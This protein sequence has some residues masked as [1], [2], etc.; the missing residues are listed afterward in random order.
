MSIPIIITAFGTTS[1][2]VATYTH[3]DAVIR[4]HFPNRE[5]IWTYS[6]RVVGRELQKAGS[7]GTLHPEQ[8]LN[9]LKDKGV[10]QAIVQS[11]HLF[12]GTEF[13]TLHRTVHDSEIHSAIGRPL[14]TSFHDYMDICD[15]LRPV[16]L[17]QQDTAILILG[18]G[19]HHPIWTA[20]Y[21]LEK[22][23]RQKYGR[24]IFVGTV[25]PYPDSSHLVDDI[26]SQGFKQV[27][28]IP[29]FL[30]AG[31]HFRRDIIG[32]SETSWKSR[33]E[34]KSIDVQSI[35]HGIGLLPG[36]EQIIV[37]HIEEA[38]EKLHP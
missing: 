25:E 32:E 9:N 19:T 26:A 13:H 30:V 24:R 35:H 22:I 27:Y 29:F 18:H 11:L 8:V 10:K 38:G 21:S 12:P 17:K 7:T 37:R 15:L 33:F 1:K 28:I 23:L 20:Y 2:A 4:P 3:L 34:A 5:V 6:S 16:I 14:F 36:I 31:F